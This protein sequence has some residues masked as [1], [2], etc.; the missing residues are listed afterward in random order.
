M[1]TY[2]LNKLSASTNGRT[3]SISATSSPGT[4]VHTA[5]SGTTNYDEVWLWIVKGRQSIDSA[6][7]TFRITTQ[8]G[9]TTSTENFN[10][11]G[12]DQEP[13]LVIPGLILNNSLAIRVYT[14]PNPGGGISLR[15][16]G[17]I[18]EIR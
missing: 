9:G 8:Y 15:A 3:I 6:Y 2:T 14:D 13:V 18:I 16:M 1:S 7:Q 5:V 12:L 10:I 4:L 11:R 17:Y